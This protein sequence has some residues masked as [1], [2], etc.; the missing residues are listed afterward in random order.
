MEDIN[1]VTVITNMHNNLFQTIDQNDHTGSFL[2]VHYNFV[3]KNDCKIY[4]ITIELGS[5]CTMTVLDVGELRPEVVL[6]MLKTVEFS[7]R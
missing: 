3:T 4:M 2:A 1:K 7:A 5:P 6:T